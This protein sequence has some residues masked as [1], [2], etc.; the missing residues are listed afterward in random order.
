VKK[1]EVTGA[2]MNGSVREVYNFFYTGRRFAVTTKFG[3][4]APNNICGSSL[5][6]VSPFR[7]LEFSGGS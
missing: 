5:L 4:V 3:T 2:C 6:F 7:R 1:A